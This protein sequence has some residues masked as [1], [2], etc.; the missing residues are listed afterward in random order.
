[1]IQ[2]RYFGA[3]G[4]Y[5]LT[6]H[7]L[8]SM[9]DVSLC[10]APCFFLRLR[11]RYVAGIGDILLGSTTRCLIFVDVLSDDTACFLFRLLSRSL[12]DVVIGSV[13]LLL[14]S[15][16]SVTAASFA[17][18]SAKSTIGY[19]GLTICEHNCCTLDCITVSPPHINTH[20]SLPHHV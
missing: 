14:L 19:S 3:V 5:I 13:L 17:I 2:R 6:Y 16:V 9:C 10:D 15:V 1:M 12:L 4:M 8:N 7:C 18:D 20:L 11:R